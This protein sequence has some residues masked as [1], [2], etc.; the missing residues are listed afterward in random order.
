[1]TDPSS[2][3]A[4][5]SGNP[6]TRSS[7]SPSVPRL[8]PLAFREHEDNR[9]RRQTPRHEREHLRRRPVKP[10]GVIDKAH[11][12]MLLRGV[13]EHAEH[14]EPDEKSI[15]LRTGAQAEGDLQRPAL[16]GRQPFAAV[17]QSDAKLMQTREG[18]LHLPF[19]A[20]RANDP[21]PHCA[22]ARV[23]EKG[24]FADPG[25]AA[26]HQDAAMAA[27]RFHDS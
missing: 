10:L 21:A 14:R 20:D 19:R 22:L 7:G 5:A 3:R 16:R 23:L 18:Q 24:R 4:E 25:L 9:L 11:Q 12:R 8:H 17:Q 1:M 6:P 26:Q 13:R 2:I 15:G 27:L